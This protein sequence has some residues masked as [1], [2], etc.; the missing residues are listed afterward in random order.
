MI[1]PVVVTD[2]MALFEYAADSDFGLS[3]EVVE[4]AFEGE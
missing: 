4:P 1:S 3:G 2:L